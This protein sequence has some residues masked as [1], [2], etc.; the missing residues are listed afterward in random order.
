MSLSWRSSVTE[1]EDRLL[2]GR[3]LVQGVGD[4]VL[5]L[6]RFQGRGGVRGAAPGQAGVGTGR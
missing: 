6:A 4:P 5:E 2:L 1:H 3:D